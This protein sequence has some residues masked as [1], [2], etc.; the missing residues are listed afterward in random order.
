MKFLNYVFSLIFL[1]FSFQLSAEVFK[2]HNEELINLLNKG[3][4]IIDIRTEEEWNSAE[5]E[6]RDEASISIELDE[7]GIVIKADTLG[8]LEA[9]AFELD[10]IK[11]P[12]QMA[13]IGMVN[14]RDL[15]TAN[16]AKDPLNCAILAFST[17]PNSEIAD[18]LNENELT[19]IE[20]EIIYHIIEK[21]ESW[22]EEREKQLEDEKRES[23]VYPGK[24]LLLRDHIFRRSSPAVVGVRVLGG[25]IQVGQH[26]MKMDGVRVGKVKSLRIGDSGIQEAMQGD[27]IAVAISN[28]VI[29]RGVDEE[30]ILLVDIPES[31]AKKVRRL[32]LNTTEMEIL[33]EITSLHRK[34]NHF[35]GR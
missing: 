25:R 20:G 29:G 14:K 10:K 11:I 5:I 23:L 17:K 22:R 16:N 9:L 31:H 27:E 35:W 19:Y 1:S 26:L 7:E 33:D 28:A 8:G 15:L 24:I 30:D 18:R 34:N 12:I 3:V 13:T 32:G 4:P 6:A 2:V 21:F